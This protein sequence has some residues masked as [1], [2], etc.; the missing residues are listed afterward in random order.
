MTPA[1]QG[2]WDEAV[3]VAIPLLLFGVLL[4]IAKRRAEREA[5]QETQDDVDPD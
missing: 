4:W 2:G 1:H 5:A 3:I